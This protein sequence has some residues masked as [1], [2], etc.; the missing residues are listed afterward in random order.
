[1]AKF[2][3]T[4]RRARKF[5][6]TEKMASR[7]TLD[8]TLSGLK[9]K[10]N[11]I[12]DHQ[13]HNPAS[14]RIIVLEADE[15]EILALMSRLPD[16]VLLE[17]EILHWTSAT[18][19][20]VDLANLQRAKVAEQF[21]VGSGLDLRVEVKSNGKP[22]EHAKV[23]LVLQTWGR[24]QRILADE[25]DAS[26]HVN[27]SHG[28]FFR[29]VALIV[30]PLGSYWNMVIQGP[31][32][33]VMIEC[34]MLPMDGPLGWWHEVLG[35]TT[36]D[37]Q[38]GRGIRIGV[39]DTG[40]GPHPCLDHVTS[41]GAFTDGELDAMKGSDSDNHGTH[42]LGI[43]GA[44]PISAGDYVGIAPGS[45]LYSAQVLPPDSGAHQGNIAMAID[46]LSKTHRVDLINISLMADQPSEI[47]LDA[48]R[49]ALER[50]TLCLCAAGNNSD[51]VS[52]PAAF[53]ETVAV[54][55][56]GFLGWP[57]EGTLAAHRLP[58]QPDRKGDEGLYLA[59][60]SSHGSAIDCTAPGVGYISTVPT[61]PTRHGLIAQYAAMDGTTMASSAACGALAV[62]L[63]Q[64]NDYLRM[65]HEKTR[66]EMARSILRRSCRDIGLAVDYQ[67]RGVPDAF[68]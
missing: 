39:V 30:I 43:I 5:N 13:P 60:F 37:E 10:V 8:R 36:N 2:V 65:P 27:F 62:L 47:V 17:P 40:V 34:P 55:A 67:G 44:R 53:S 68:S 41:I 3:L 22:L 29:P 14:R 11:V 59:D 26:G 15:A 31:S 48:I 4:N 32:D 6:D 20:P 45:A 64:D 51:H 9:P 56:L 50:G 61:P 23:F 28:W 33:P 24:I 49:D 21:L 52:Y 1:M 38:R 57:P 63:S 18:L 25:T 35:I 58:M 54:S 46:A 19:F 42:V 66:G 16:D 12:H 7:N